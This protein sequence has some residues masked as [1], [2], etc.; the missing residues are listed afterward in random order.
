MDELIGTQSKYFEFVLYSYWCRLRAQR[1]LLDSDVYWKII[2][3]SKDNTAE[4]DQWSL[5]AVFHATLLCVLI[6][7]RKI[8]IIPLAVVEQYTAC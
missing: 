8:N 5:S 4:S 1:T 3:N 7:I 6:S 2:N